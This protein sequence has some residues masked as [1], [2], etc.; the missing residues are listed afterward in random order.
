MVTDQPGL[1]E[2][3]AQAWSLMEAFFTSAQDDTV[4]IDLVG[5][6]NDALVEEI[7][8]LAGL[9]SDLDASTRSLISS[10][11]VTAVD[12][13]EAEI[14]IETP[15]LDLARTLAFRTSDVGVLLRAYRVG[16]RLAW[17]EFTAILT[18]EVVDPELRLAAMA[19]LFDR[20]SVELERIVDASVSVFTAERD[21]W[22]GGALARKAEV[23]AGL[24]RGEEYDVDEA[25]QV[26]AHRLH[27]HQLAIVAW[28]DDSLDA[29]DALPR[30]EALAR[31]VATALRA[32]A[33]L[34]V[35]EGARTLSG[36][37]NVSVDPDPDALADLVGAA[38]RGI[39]LA[40]GAPGPGV[41]GFRASH[42]QAMLARR[43]ALASALPLPVTG[44]R[45]IAVLSPYLDDPD[46]LHDLLVTELAGLDGRDEN[47]VRLR[48]T[49]LAYLRAGGSAR[50]AA[51][52]LGVHKNTVLY[53][54][55]GI[56]EALGHPLTEGR[57]PLEIALS[58][59]EQL[60]DGVLP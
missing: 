12:D 9:R 11:F 30:L 46:A 7:P 59:V 48:E 16:Q 55:R 53:R 19:F 24:L 51:V 58:L 21:Q 25:T 13:P 56:E 50:D 47:A 37:L 49:M 45:S 34:T 26:L 60:G 3:V 54:L 2:D 42:R 43:V 38:G 8:E 33:P 1:T 32:P 52:A 31:S 17:R 14:E 22:L 36:W 10:F 20:L 5:R 6:L 35:P 28:Q 39:H 41:A 18:R 27:P 44:Y 4:V 23:V 57:L 29:A 15:V 40:F